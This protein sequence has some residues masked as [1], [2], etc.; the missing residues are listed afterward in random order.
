MISTWITSLYVSQPSSVVFQRKTA[1]FGPELQVFKGTRPHLSFCACNKVWLTTELL[2]LWVPALICGFCMQ[3][4]DFWSRITSLCGS[5]TSPVVLCVQNSVMRLRLYRSQPLSVFF[6]CKTASF[7]AE[8]QVS[9]GPRPHLSFCAC[10]A[11]CLASELPVSM[12]PR[13]HLWILIANQRL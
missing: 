11:S 12:G 5:H 8:L 3:N 13:P 6:A 4:S 10:T 2:Y 1:H 7:G 9:M